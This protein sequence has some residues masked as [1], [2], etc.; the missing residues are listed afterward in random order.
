M[1]RAN[2]TNFDLNLLI[3]EGKSSSARLNS[4]QIANYFDAE[5]KI[6]KL[7]DYHA[8][9]NLLRTNRFDVLL[10]DIDD[11]EG[12]DILSRLCHL[13]NEALVIALSDGTSVSLALNAMSAGAHDHIAKPLDLDDFALRLEEL[14][15][16]YGKLN[17]I[18][19]PNIAKSDLIGVRANEDKKYCTQTKLEFTSALNTKPKNI[20]S[21][22]IKPE[23]IKPM[24][25][26]EQKIIEDAIV[27]FNGNISRA[28]KALEIS[29]ST[30]YRKK[31][32]WQAAI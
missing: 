16:I 5:S 18:F 11:I 21:E 3:L 31:Q 8:A 12:K 22:N 1:E 29:P 24:W 2:I 27:F 14:S 7:N 13:A 6:V 23:N 20:K 32:H 17:H 30:I 19:K 25:Q 15:S 28:A 10:V 26:Q 4:K 9:L